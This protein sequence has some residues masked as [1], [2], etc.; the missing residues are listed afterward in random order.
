[1]LHKRSETRVN[2]KSICMIY[3]HIYISLLLLVSKKCSIHRQRAVI[4]YGIKNYTNSQHCQEEGKVTKLNNK[5][6]VTK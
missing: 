6:T 2:A 3:I 5:K 4:K 1:M